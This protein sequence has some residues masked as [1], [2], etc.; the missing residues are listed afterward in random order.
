MIE[1]DTF[2]FNALSPTE[3]MR[4]II[5]AVVL[6]LLV[7]SACTR[8]S[9][10][11]NTRTDG[12]VQGIQSDPSGQARN[13]LDQGKALYRTDE[14]KRAL[15]AFQEALKLDPELAEAHFRSG[16]AYS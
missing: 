3:Q 9:R 15:D 16:L 12:S 2:C 13:Y 8:K 10:Q 4:L 7:A 11:S 6:C 1:V 14:D 5:F